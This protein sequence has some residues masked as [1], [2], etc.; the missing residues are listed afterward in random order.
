MRKHCREQILSRKINRHKKPS[1]CAYMQQGYVT[2]YSPRHELRS[3]FLKCLPAVGFIIF[4]VFCS[5]ELKTIKTERPEVHFHSLM[6]LAC[7]PFIQDYVRK[8]WVVRR[9]TEQPQKSTDK[10]LIMISSWGK[11]VQDYPVLI[12][13]MRSMFW[14]RGTVPRCLV[15]A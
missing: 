9:Q 13:S 15:V 1:K 6:H 3:H 11:Q 10:H 4:K 8:G 7:R 2:L 5:Q 12:T 14:G